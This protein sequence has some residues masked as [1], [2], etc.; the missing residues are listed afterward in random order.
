MAQ[1]PTF[2]ANVEVRG[3]ASRLRVYWP[4]RQNY[5]GYGYDKFGY[6][7]NAGFGFGGSGAGLSEALYAGVLCQRLQSS[8]TP[9]GN[10]V[11]WNQVSWFTERVGGAI[12]DESACFE[13]SV[14]VAYGGIAGG[15]VPLTFDSGLYI[16][17]LLQNGKPFNSVSA[18]VEFGVVDTGVVSLRAYANNG[19]GVP[20]INETVAAALTPDVTKMNTY[21][22]RCITGSPSTDPVLYG[23]INGQVVTQRYSWTAA[24]GLMPRPNNNA[25][26]P[27]YVVGF[28]NYSNGILQS[29]YVH[30]LRLTLAATEADL[31]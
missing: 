4:A 12:I 19:G 24:A 15:P 18:G 9:D 5:N 25:G 14:T 16:S 3:A 10:W 2:A 1:Q 26:N 28:T 30:E 17:D 20:Q 27:G 23:L 6:V 29:A 13:M 31:D 7:D 22:V 8:N 11:Q 21:G